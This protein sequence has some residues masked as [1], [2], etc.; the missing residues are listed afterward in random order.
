MAKEKLLWTG[1]VAKFCGVTP[2]AVFKWIRA[3]ALVASRT[4]GGQYRVQRE[5]LVRFLKERGSLVPAELADRAT[6]VL[7]VDDDDTVAAVVCHVLARRWPDWEV[8]P[9][10]DG[11]EA[12]KLIHTLEPDLV[13]LDLRMPTV[14]GF[15]VCRDLKS[16]PRTR[17]IRVLVMTGYASDENIELALQSGADSLIKKPLTPQQIEHAV[18]SVFAESPRKPSR[19]GRSRAEPPADPSPPA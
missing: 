10:R 7:V 11:Y 6:R 8:T 15:A 1:Q 19:R 3:G 13:V 16:D 2:A 9:A 18:E 5:D 12:G 17:H 4:P 14:D